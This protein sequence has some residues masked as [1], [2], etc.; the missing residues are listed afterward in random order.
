M[1]LRE[2]LPFFNV[3]AGG[4]ATMDF[5][6]G[7]TYERLVLQLGGQTFKKEHITGI[8]CKLN[9]KVFHD[10][11]GPTLD[12]MNAYTGAAIDPNFLVLDFTEIFARDQVGQSVGAI[13]TAKGVASFTMEV[14]IAPGA[15][16]PTLKAWTWTSAPKELS[17]VNKLLMYPT[18]F[19][20]AG[21][22]PIK[23]PFGAAGGSLV[24]RIYFGHNKTM[25]GFE[26]KMNGLSI[27]KSV[28]AVNEFIA[29]D[30][31]KV[32]QEGLYVY[33][34]IVDNNMTEILD[35][36]R[37]NSLELWVTINAAD[38]IRTYVEYLDPLGNL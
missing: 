19:S 23:I 8:K 32:P 37:A 21:T 31:R 33:D 35:T 4:I 27:H 2:E 25:T 5:P 1:L 34:P 16:Q 36:T 13:A 24:K 7:Q 18:N 10:V 11:D 15:V 6:L 17:V 20:T 29:R 14:S 26:L 30:N 28:S 3:V 38:T 22:F 9:G 12:K